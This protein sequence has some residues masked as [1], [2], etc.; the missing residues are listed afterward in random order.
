MTRSLQFGKASHLVSPVW[1]TFRF[2]SYTYLWDWQFRE[3]Y[4][5][6]DCCKAG[7]ESTAYGV[8]CRACDEIIRG[9]PQNDTEALALAFDRELSPL[10]AIIVAVAVQYRLTAVIDHM[11]RTRR[12][13]QTFMHRFDGDL[14]V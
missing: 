2:G 6:S 13:P 7:V 3:V 8:K 5:A 4:T 14:N 1:L 12:Q 9:V 11:D 10:E